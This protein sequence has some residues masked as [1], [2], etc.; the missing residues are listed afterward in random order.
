[1]APTPSACPD[2]DT[3]ARFAQG[4]LPP[5]DVAR[6]EQH[7]DQ[8]PVCAELV[9]AL[10]RVGGASPPPSVVPSVR[11][12]PEL[13]VP[14]ELVAAVL[15][16]FWSALSLPPLVSSL[17]SGGERAAL[18]LI[19]AGYVVVWAPLGGLVA[20]VAAWGSGRLRRW[21]RG[22]A[23]VHA[24]VSLPSLVL[25]PIAAFVLFLATRPSLREASGIAP[26]AH[27]PLG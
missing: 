7:I 20:L 5:A 18:P 24:V 26:T 27:L 23:V 21:G 8:C 10:G 4:L 3:M 25:L 6:L 14:T 1:M 12:P 22:M 19:A 11:P 9:V 13:L 16:A 2:D 17:A 15:H